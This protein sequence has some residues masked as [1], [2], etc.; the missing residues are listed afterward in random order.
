MASRAVRLPVKLPG[1]GGCWVRL[2]PGRVWA[3]FHPKAPG[4]VSRC[5]ICDRFVLRGL[6]KWWEQS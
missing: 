4:G 3:T 6:G 2:S 1:S 5:D